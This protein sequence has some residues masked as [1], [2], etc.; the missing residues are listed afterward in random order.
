MLWYRVNVCTGKLGAEVKV[1]L[2]FYGFAV[3][4]EQ[5]YMD[6][7]PVVRTEPIRVES[8][9]SGHHLSPTNFNNTSTNFTRVSPFQNN[10]NFSHILGISDD[11]NGDIN[12]KSKFN[13]RNNTSSSGGSDNSDGESG[14]S[15]SSSSSTD[16]M[17]MEILNSPMINDDTDSKKRNNMII[18]DVFNNDITSDDE[19]CSNNFSSVDID[20]MFSN[21]VR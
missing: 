10:A 4:G 21:C 16:I 5:M 6:D 20:K 13:Y 11:G 9:Q 2:E 8:V 15:S 1:V 17:K 19:S 7:Q 14:G 3:V 18:Y 12:K